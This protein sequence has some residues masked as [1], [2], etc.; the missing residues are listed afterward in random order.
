[1]VGIILFFPCKLSDGYTCLFEHFKG[2]GHGHNVS[3][4]LT[5]NHAHEMA[6]HYVLP[7]GLIWWFSIAIAWWGILESRKNRGQKFNENR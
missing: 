4:Q 2:G 6:Q 1:L 5:I 3:E 7:F